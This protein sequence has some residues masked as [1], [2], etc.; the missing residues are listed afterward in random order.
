MRKCGHTHHHVNLYLGS[1]S[2]NPPGYVDGE[3]Q[4]LVG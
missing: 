1:P 2:G 3:L 4:I